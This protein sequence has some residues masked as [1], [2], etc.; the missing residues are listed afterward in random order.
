MLPG[1]TRAR[2]T[3]QPDCLREQLSTR[4]V[5]SRSLH[6]RPYAAPEHPFPVSLLASD[7]ISTL[8]PRHFFPR[9]ALPIRNAP[10]RLIPSFLFRAR[11]WPAD[12]Q[13]REF[14]VPVDRLSAR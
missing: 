8:A 1:A 14:V 5:Q 7:L 2:K 11:S 10:E 13:A 9:L 12:R 3:A 4:S 6:R